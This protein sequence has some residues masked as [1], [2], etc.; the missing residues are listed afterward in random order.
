[1]RSTPDRI[2]HA[3]SFEV[4]GILLV[5]PAAS[6]AFALPG[7]DTGVV[8][9]GSA[10]IAMVWNYGYNL[11]FDHALQAISGTLRKSLPMRIVHAILFELGLLI[12][13]VPVI[14]WYL[15]IGLR[16]TLLLDL[17]LALFYVLY[18]F[19]FNCIYDRV[20]PVRA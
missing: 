16:Q 9:M 1:L 11:A 17:S 18:A 13:L 4:L 6:W 8:A 14:A 10:T 19:A 7:A 2:R 20:F 5:T 3:V 12:V 15:G